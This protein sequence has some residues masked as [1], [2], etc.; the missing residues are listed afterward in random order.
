MKFD[1]HRPPIN[2]RGDLKNYLYWTIGTLTFDEIEAM[3]ELL[4][5]Y[6]PAIQ[7]NEEGR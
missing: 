7:S 4:F 6:I 3:I 2:S 1:N 5:T